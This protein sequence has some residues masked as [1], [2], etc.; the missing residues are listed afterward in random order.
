MAA[1]VAAYVPVEGDVVVDVVG[2]PDHE[3]VALPHDELR[4]RELAVHRGD[5]LRHAQP[6]HRRHCHLPLHIVAA[7]KDHRKQT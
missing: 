6:R 4:P 2:D 3:G 7:A 1:R 5:A